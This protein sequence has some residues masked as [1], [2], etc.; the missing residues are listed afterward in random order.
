[1]LRSSASSDLADKKKVVTD[2]DMEAI[3][4][5][6]FYQPPEIWKLNHIQVSCGD[7]S[8]PTASVSL[9]G[10]DGK[11]YMDAALGTGPVDAV[12]QAVNRIVGASNTLTEFTINA[13]TEGLGCRR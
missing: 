12:Y 11:T 7:H 2:A 4:A 8:M 6:E 5:D 13:V 3:I 1:M 10:P 9:T